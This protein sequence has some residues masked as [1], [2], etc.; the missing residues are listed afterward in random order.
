LTA[1]LPAAG[2]L[3]WAV[4][5]MAAGI[6]IPLVAESSGFARHR[7]AASVPFAIGIYLPTLIIGYIRLEAI[8]HD[9][10]VR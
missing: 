2:G 10:N 3:L 8:F 4:A 7:E 9:E 6:F 5:F 1:H